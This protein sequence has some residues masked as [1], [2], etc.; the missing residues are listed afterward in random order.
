MKKYSKPRGT[1]DLLPDVNEKREYLLKIFR[2][3]VKK[4]GFREIKTP[5]IE[6]AELFSVG[7]G[8]ATDIVNKEMYV[9]EDK[10]KHNLA[11]RPESTTGIAR[12]YVENELS[13]IAPDGIA[14][15]FYIEPMFRYE[16][17]QAGRYRQ[18]TQYGVELIGD[19]SILADIDVIS[20][21]MFFLKEIGLTDFS[22]EINNIGCPKCRKVHRQALVQYLEKKVDE[23]CKDCRARL[24]RNPLRIL[25]CK[26]KY[27][28][29][30][31]KKAPTPIQFFCQNCQKDFEQLQEYLKVLSFKY[32]INPFLV[33][34]L[35]YYT[36]TVFEIT[37]SELGS[38]NTLIGGGRYNGLIELL[39]RRPTPGVGFGGGLERLMLEM[40]KKG[41]LFPVKERTDVYII[42][43][44]DSLKTEALKIM[45]QLKK[46]D[47]STTFSF[48]LSHIKSQLVK[49]LKI[50]AKYA[51]ILGK[52]EQNKKLVSLKNLDNGLQETLPI[53]KVIEKLKE[54]KG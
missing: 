19:K 10:S 47:I 14:R 48:S 8:N 29:K 40:E 13:L 21:G 3:V 32:K 38:Q 52:K 22:L 11:L 45:N 33:R 51:L 49:A 6:K 26:N 7:V 41:I 20:M 36:G 18:H 35:N 53:E 50:N 43:L 12:A 17:P 16:R 23:L 4:G 34:G 24:K 9:F 1:I 54:K 39:G 46:N 37:S 31:I 2:N 27:C 5:I 15:L 25:D 28:K 42:V 30:V 44:D